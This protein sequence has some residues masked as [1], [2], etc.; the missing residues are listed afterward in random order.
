M[1]FPEE[2]SRRRPFIREG[3]IVGDLIGN[4]Y[5][6]QELLLLTLDDVTFICF[7]NSCNS[8]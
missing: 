6:A 5:L 1:L 8:D 3:I 7:G 4:F 2:E